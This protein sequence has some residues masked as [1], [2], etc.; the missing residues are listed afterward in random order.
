MNCSTGLS[1]RNAAKSRDR[2]LPAPVRVARRVVEVPSESLGEEEQH[3]D[4][5]GR[6]D[7]KGS[8]HGVDVLAEVRGTPDLAVERGTPVGPQVEEDDHRNQ[9][10]RRSESEGSKVRVDATCVEGL[11]V[12]VA[13]RAVELLGMGVKRADEVCVRVE[14]Q[15]KEH[16]HQPDDPTVKAELLDAGVGPHA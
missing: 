10:Q 8:A 5:D 2:A 13:L 3:D 1:N 9:E 11:L 6:G 16:D 4:G 12:S 14:E 15:E 7:Y